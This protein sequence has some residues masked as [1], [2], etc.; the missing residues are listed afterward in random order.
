MARS[1]S[2]IFNASVARFVA[3]MAGIGITVDP[4]QWS[5][6]NQVSA[7]LYTGSETAAI[8]EQI[9]DDQ[10]LK[11]ENQMLKM[12]TGNAAMIQASILNYFQY[13]ATTPQIIQLDTTTGAYYYPTIDATKRIVTQCRVISGM[14]NQVLI[15]CAKT[16]GGSLTALTSDEQTAL[17]SYIVV[18]GTAG[19][20]YVVS[21]TNS[22]KLMVGATVTYN[23]LYS[24]V[25]KGNLT[26]A[27]INYLNSLPFTGLFRL[28]DL[29]VV[30]RNV[31]GVIDVQFN[32]I[33]TRA[34][35]TPFVA[36]SYN[37]VQAN[38]ELAAYWQTQSGYIV[39]ET[40]SGYTLNDTLTLIPA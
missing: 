38:T 17:Q 10:L 14:Y 22:D 27:I 11:L 31:T 21:S 24:A 26:N 20:A 29:M 15:K 12:P 25:I 8:Q 23:G 28:S 3:Y 7:Y 37:M 36:G 39:P 2:Q 34:D 13:D 35:G 16:V 30:M 19:I 18:T 5:R 6:Q 40:T 33:N 32:N 4:T 1:I 9:N